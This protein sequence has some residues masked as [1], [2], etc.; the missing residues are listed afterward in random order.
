MLNIKSFIDAICMHEG[1]NQSGLAG[2]IG[3]TVPALYR[4]T[5]KDAWKVRIGELES[6]VHKSG[7][8]LRIELLDENGV[9]RYSMDSDPQHPLVAEEVIKECR[10]TFANAM[11]DSFKQSRK[12]KSE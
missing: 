6:I 3:Y 2:K 5:G 4:K 11:T 10:E 7:Y 1:V 8:R 9:S 12:N